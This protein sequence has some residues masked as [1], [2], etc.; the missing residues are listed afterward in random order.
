M[1]KILALLAVAGLTSAFAEV[2]VFGNFD[3]SLYRGTYGGQ[4][5]TSTTYNGGST[6]HF[7]FRGSEKLNGSTT[8]SFELQSELNLNSGQVGS[9]TTGISNTDS[10]L[11][12]VFNRAAWIQMSNNDF[13]SLRVGRQQNAWWETVTKYN[14]TGINSFGWIAAA[15]VTGGSTTQHL[16]YNGTDLSAAGK[17]FNFMG[18]SSNNPSYTGSNEAFMGGI[19]YV[20]PKIGN[21]SAKVQTGT[22]DQ[23]YTTAAGANN[24]RGLALDY[25][26]DALK[27]GYGWDVKQ[28]ANGDTAWTQRVIGA[29]YQLG[30]YT[31]TAARNETTF[32]SLARSQGAHNLVIN[33]LGIGT[34]SGSWNY[35]LG[36]TKLSDVDN[37]NNSA[38]YVGV[39]ARYNFSKTASWYAGA[40]QTKNEGQSR[41]GPVYGSSGTTIPVAGDVGKTVN[42]MLTGV[43]FQF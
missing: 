2:T 16:V 6:S 26:T 23:S 40:G 43:R 7:G 3:Q 19:T 30:Q 13:G 4:S 14:N 37:S 20:T 18:A 12:T 11:S 1:K 38:R 33:A 36:L 21:F 5:M 41:L 8:A 24:A 17:V 34:S 27:V 29:K 42:A 22:I 9:S 10:R 31:L 35:D 25:E 39:V 32:G 15:A 28:D